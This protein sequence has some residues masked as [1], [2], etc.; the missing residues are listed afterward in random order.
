[1]WTTHSVSL[2]PG[3]PVCCAEAGGSPEKNGQWSLVHKVTLFASQPPLVPPRC[4]STFVFF[5]H[6]GPQAHLSF[7]SANPTGRLLPSPRAPRRLHGHFLLGP[8]AF[9]ALGKAP[10]PHKDMVR[11]PRGLRLINIASRIRIIDAPNIVITR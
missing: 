2:L 5:C 9:S 7:C 11:K 1:M 8:L 6:K 4:Y 10:A 3:L